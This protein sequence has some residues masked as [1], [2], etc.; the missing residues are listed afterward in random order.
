LVSRRVWI[1][2]LAFA[3]AATQFVSVFTESANWDELALFHRTERSASTGTLQGGGRPGLAVLALIPFVQACTDTM[4]TIARVRLVWVAITLGILAA[5]FFLLQGAAR[6]SEHRVHAAALGVAMIALVPVFMRWSVQVRTDQP[7]VAAALWASVALLASRRRPWLAT[8]AGVL[9][10]VGYLFSQKAVYV[11]ALGTAIVLGDLIVDGP[12]VWTREFRRIARRIVWLA[13]GAALVMFA[14]VTALTLLNGSMVPLAPVS[15]VLNVFD[16]YRE[17]FGYRVYVGMLPTLYPHVAGLVLLLL[18][19]RVAHRCKTARIRPL[20]VALAVAALGL[21]VGA[22]HA[23]AFPYFWITL[24]LFPACAIGLGWPAIASTW[25][26]ASRPIAVGL[27]AWLLII[28]VPYRVEMLQDTQAVQRETFG[29]IQR[30]FDMTARGFNAD[31][32]LFCRRDPQPF[33]VYL[34]EHVMRTFSGPDGDRQADLFIAEFRTRPVAFMIE[35]FLLH[36]FPAKVSE[37]WATHYVRYHGSAAVAGRKVTGSAGTQIDVDIIVPGNYRWSGLGP[38]SIEGTRLE[39]G[40]TIRLSTG[41]HAMT[42]GED[43]PDGVLALALPEPPQPS[44]LPF[45]PW[46]PVAE[47]AGSRWV[48]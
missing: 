35:D 5:L 46:A 10:V 17:R 7:A 4:A 16:Y 26:T 14:W 25:P 1:T 34:H 22:F 19:L 43:T 47:I 24:G 36:P 32:G 15:A 42:L 29:F 30:N 45:H 27:W 31:G 28:A 44:Q 37:F 6:E 20:L 18:A 39:P 9:F 33:P 23:A 40:A 21:A 2:L 12:A 11:G 48:W 38:I 3:F 8:V 13:I 41:G